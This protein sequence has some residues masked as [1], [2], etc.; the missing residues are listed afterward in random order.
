MNQLAFFMAGL[1][2][3]AALS[4]NDANNVSFTL[5]YSIVSILFVLFGILLI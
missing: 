1:T 4:A 3:G 2:M 5:F